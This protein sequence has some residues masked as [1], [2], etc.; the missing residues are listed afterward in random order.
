M[1]KR[2]AARILVFLL[3]GAIVNVAVA[4]GCARWAN[5]RHDGYFVDAKPAR[6]SYESA[7]C[8]GAVRIVSS[9]T[10]ETQVVFRGDETPNRCPAPAWSR[11]TSQSKESA[12]LVE[13]ARG[14]PALALMSVLTYID[15]DVDAGW[16]RAG[17]EFF[18]PEVWQTR[19]GI[20]VRDGR[21]AEDIHT[22]PLRPIWP[23]FA[24]NTV[25][26]AG[27]LWVLL[28]APF[29]LRR[30]L[31]IKRGLCP[32]CAYDLRG[33]GSGGAASACPECGAEHVQ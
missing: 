4:W 13:D 14:W 11:V 30:R 29:A 5:V 26:Y 21:R 20:R 12:S 18:I 9:P 33:R 15:S 27:M 8:F 24:I 10:T 28:A 17:D 31:R 6:W 16:V 23:G 19:W 2:W 3:L 7:S 32:K 1:K 25:F 22:L